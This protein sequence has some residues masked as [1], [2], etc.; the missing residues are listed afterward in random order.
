MDT[1]PTELQAVTVKLQTER[2]ELLP[3]TALQLE[4]WLKKPDELEREI[5][6]SYRATP[7]CGDFR[8]VVEGQLAA[9]RADAQRNYPWHTFW[10]LIR[11]YDRVVV[12]SACFHGAPV[13]TG[14]A[15]IGYGLG[16]GFCGQGYMTEAVQAITAWALAQPGVKTVIA[17]TEIDNL[18]SQNVLIRCGF[19]ERS[20][21]ESVWFEK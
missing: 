20:R 6:C 7:L 11:R 12:G 3:L 10:F 14:E 15:E 2:L 13:E 21:G 16:D 1:I 17:E 4:K 9:A 5:M 19:R 8:T 18:P